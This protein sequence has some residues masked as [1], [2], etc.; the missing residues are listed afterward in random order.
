MPQLRHLDLSGTRITDRGLEVLRDLPNLET[1]SLAWTTI[2]DSGVAALARCEHLTRVDL[3]GTAT[4]DGAIKALGGKRY[5]RTFSTGNRV[6]DAGVVHL[7]AYPV[8]KSWQATGAPEASLEMDGGPNSLMLRGAITDRGLAAL[9]GL[10]GLFGLNVWDINLAITAPGLASLASL[11]KLGRLAVEAHDESMPYIAALPHLR[12]LMIQDTD[13]GDDGWVAL[14]QSQSIEQIWG[15]QC[16]NLRSRGFRALAKLPAL[17]NLAVSCRNVDDEAVA[18]LPD[19]PSLREIM[20]MD[21]PDEGYRH[22][23]RCERLERLTLMYCRD[24]TDRATE[25]II[26]M[27]HLKRYFASYTQ[28]TDRT[29]ELLSGIESL[30]DVEFSACAGLTNAGIAALARLPGLRKLGLGGMPR[31]TREVIGRFAAAV[32]VHYSG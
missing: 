8:F 30:E 21:I 32:R 5:L 6:T 24:T 15:R 31:V 7:H 1:I 4:G 12:F 18:A 28:I 29:P 10:D 25:H 11:P 3:G 13:A 22:I 14:S 27:R 16:H 20:P 17:G 9:V 19:F 23:A 26:G 2:T